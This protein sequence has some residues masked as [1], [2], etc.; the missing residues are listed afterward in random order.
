MDIAAASEPQPLKFINQ[1]AIQN[2]FDQI[3]AKADDCQEIPEV[4]CRVA[5]GDC[6]D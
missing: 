6:F 1:S 4:S 5:S 3:F 2:V